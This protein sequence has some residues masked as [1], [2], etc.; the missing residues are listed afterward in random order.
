MRPLF[1]FIF[2]LFTPVILSQ[3]T[4]PSASGMQMTSYPSDPLLKHPVYV[5]CNP[6]G[7][8][9]GTLVAAS[10]GGSAPFT[11]S[12]HKWNTA[13][14]DFSDFIRTDAGVST[15]SLTGLEEG[16]YRAHITDGSGYD[17]MLVAWVHLD[18]P[19]AEARLQNFTCDYVALAGKAVA[20]TFYYYDPSGGQAVKLGN[21]V[22]FIWSSTPS[23]SIPFPNI[24]I[25]PVT[26]NPPLED[27]V[28]KL[29]VTDNFGC[30]SESSFPYASIHVKADFKADP[31]TG[32]AP[33]QVNFEDK[34]V[35]GHKYLWKFGDKDTSSARSPEHI[36][37][38]PGEYT[39]TLIVESENLCVDSLL[40]EKIVVEPS[41]LDIPNVF[42]PDGDG[43]NDFFVVES[44]SL[45]SI[46]VEIYSRSGMMVYSFY[47]E[48]ERLA[49][50]QGWDGNVNKSS[51]KAAPGIYFYIIR[52][53]G[54][55]DKIYEGKQYRGFFYLYR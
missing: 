36:Y 20:D 12:W 43:I 38:K 40:F 39:V 23:S 3:I 33:L 44:K 49:G 52:A 47:G 26:Y 10:P 29:Q 19:F 22:T 46:S 2:L 28:Y 8:I 31:V 45:R 7:S 41:S 6:S 55:D 50:W 13:T 14:K 5:F 37:Y 4:A 16:G 30:V 51:V 1:V 18:R 27:V 48:G 32:E 25:N 54:W 24:E 42:T 9:K 35:R 34:S 17:T 21:P 11:F 53:R 15:S